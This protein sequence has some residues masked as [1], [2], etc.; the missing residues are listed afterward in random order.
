MSEH[1]AM[2]RT[3]RELTDPSALDDVLRRA[4]VL[5]VAMVDEGE[6]YVLPFDFGYEPGPDGGPA[7]G[8]LFVHCAEEGRKLDVIAREPRV[9]F[10]AEVDHEVVPGTACSW[11]AYFRSVVGWGTAR[12]VADRAER[13]RALE[14]L[15]EHYSGQPES[16][17]PAS[18]DGVAVIRIDIERVTGKARDRRP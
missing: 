8:A 2:R 4:D 11:T 6:P 17:P 1:R 5:F 12:L 10:T 14:R 18:A 13:A 15:I 3:D 16:L 9:C 7:G